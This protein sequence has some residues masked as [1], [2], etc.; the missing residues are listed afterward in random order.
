MKRG[1]FFLKGKRGS[2]EDK[3]I[4]WLFELLLAALVILLLLKWTHSVVEDTLFYKLYFSRDLSMFSNA[5]H[6]SPYALSSLYPKDVTG[7]TIEFGDGR[8]YVDEAKQFEGRKLSR[9]KYPFQSDSSIGM[10]HPT[11]EYI[12]IPCQE[13]PDKSLG[14][15][16]WDWLMGKDCFQEPSIMRFTLEGHNITI[17]KSPAPII[18]LNSIKCSNADIGDVAKNV[19]IDTNIEEPLESS[20]G[21]KNEAEIVQNIASILASSGKPS[22]I[23]LDETNSNGLLI[24][25]RMND[26]LN[27]NVKV[28]IGYKLKGE[29]LAKA[30]K[31]ACLL[32]NNLAEMGVSG[33]SVQK[34]KDEMVG[35][36]IVL[37]LELGSIEAENRLIGNPETASSIW[38]AIDD[39]YGDKNEG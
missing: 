9:V 36:E 39:F 1:F 2:W 12:P 18:N 21:T 13:P 3:L 22:G 17:D 29:N 26:D 30:Q 24:K 19:I 35:A 32:A 15:K 16:A 4:L 14:D 5:V 7:F 37:N 23:S 20:D 10:E 31:L 27:N 38:T 28:M 6:A 34:T 11:F 25:L 8:I 33:T